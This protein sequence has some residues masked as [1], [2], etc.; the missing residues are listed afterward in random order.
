M[1]VKCL[2]GDA[3]LDFIRKNV[4]FVFFLLLLFFFCVWMLLEEICWTRTNAGPC[5]LG[6]GRSCSVNGY[7]SGSQAADG[8]R[9]ERLSCKIA[10][11]GCE[12]WKKCSGDTEED[13]EVR[14]TGLG[15]KL[16]QSEIKTV[17]ACVH[18]LKYG[19]LKY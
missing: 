13:V 6:S 12:R 5:E 19:L 7:T 8:V 16:C 18:T 14:K 3:T 11:R 17:N 15:V 4:C 2:L 10:R 1:E 9:R